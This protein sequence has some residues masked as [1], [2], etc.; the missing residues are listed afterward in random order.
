MF[1][2]RRDVTLLEV[3]VAC[4]IAI[5]ALGTLY[6]GA[7]SGMRATLSAEHVEAARVLARSLLAG[8]DGM[9]LVPRTLEGRDGAGLD[10]RLQVSPLASLA[11]PASQNAQGGNLDAAATQATLYAI[12]VVVTQ[13]GTK[14]TLIRLD[15]ARIDSAPGKS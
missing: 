12:S 4:A 8:V 2:E 3:L 1:A 15:S 10:W 7:V 11:L 13:P 14:R 9:V 5:A 6:Q